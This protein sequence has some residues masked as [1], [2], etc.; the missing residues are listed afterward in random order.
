[1]ADAKLVNVPLGGNFK[2]SEAQTSTTEDEK[3]LICEVL[4]ASV[5]GSLMYVMVCTRPEITQAIRVV[6]RYISN[7]RN[8][9]WRAMKWILRYLKGNSDMSLCYGGTDVQVLGYVDSDFAG[10]IDSRRS[11]ISHVFTL[12]SGVVSWISRL[13]KIVALSTMEVSMSQRQKLPRIF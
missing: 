3:A 13:Q 10:D 6:S 9:H 11:T 12:G 2:L 8:E 7:P 4:Y 5:V 1:M